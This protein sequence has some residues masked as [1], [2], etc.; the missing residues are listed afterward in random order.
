MVHVTTQDV[1]VRF[2]YV[3]TLAISALDDLSVFQKISGSFRDVLRRLIK[4]TSA[5][6][7]QQP[8][9]CK[10]Q[11]LASEVG[12]S[13]PTIYR[14]LERFEKEG[15]I[16]REW[17]AC[18]GFRG[19]ESHIT[20]TKALCELLGLPTEGKSNRAEPK[21]ARAPAL[22]QSSSLPII[23]DR[24]TEDQVLETQPLQGQPATSGGS[25]DK[26]TEKQ[27]PKTIRFG[28]FRIPSE[29]SWLI[30]DQDMIPSGVLGLMK[31]ATSVGQRLSDV[32]SFA[33]QAVKKF[34]GRQLFAYLRT[35]I[36]SGKDWGFMEGQRIQGVESKAKAVEVKNAHKQFCESIRGLYFRSVDGS[37]AFAVG[38]NGYAN[39]AWVKTVSERGVVIAGG[40]PSIPEAFAAAV[41]AGRIVECSASEFDQF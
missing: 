39:G 21:K 28:Q 3:I 16:T 8:I 7:G 10:R 23:A 19:S 18:A 4:K 26:S 6:N 30:S 15:W 22:Q 20:F 38:A 37:K 33:M 25:V 24:S 14:A 13:I 35:L 36:T 29:L 32:V 17:H 1:C 2:P 11:T 12:C 31:L 34:R 27:P 9:F 41:N 40:L 5:I